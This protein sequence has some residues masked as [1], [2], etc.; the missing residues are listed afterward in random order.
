MANL[1]G[2]LLTAFF[3]GTHPQDHVVHKRR[4][5][6]RR[7]LTLIVQIVVEP[8]NFARM[9]RS[10]VVNWLTLSVTWR[11]AAACAASAAARS[12]FV[13]ISF[14][15]RIARSSRAA[16]LP[17]GVWHPT[18]PGSNS[19]ARTST[20]P[21]A[22]RVYAA[23]R[24]RHAD[25]EPTHRKSPSISVRPVGPTARQD[26]PASDSLDK[27]AAATRSSGTRS[28]APRAFIY[29]SRIPRRLGG[30]KFGFRQDRL[31]IG[32]FPPDRPFPPWRGAKEKAI[33][34]GLGRNRH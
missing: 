1:V 14:L 8:R 10:L 6:F 29:R 32:R 31:K 5:D 21:I 7:A 13:A 16:E 15:M 24:A 34:K 17:V 4:L 22:R 23:R 19:N 9:S 27:R 33:R 28:L 18:I 20:H 11:Y 30:K 25:K 3:E 26:H 2:G 12:C